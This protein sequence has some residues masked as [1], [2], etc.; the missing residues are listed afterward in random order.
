MAVPPTHIEQTHLF[1]GCN[2]LL[3]QYKSIGSELLK[4]EGHVAS[5][6]YTSRVAQQEFRE[7]I[8]FVPLE[9]LES[10]LEDLLD[11]E[12]PEEK[13]FIRRE[14]FN[15]PPVYVAFAGLLLAMG[16][17]IYAASAGASFFFSFAL[18]ASLSFPF[19]YMWQSTRSSVGRRMRFAQVL[20]QEVSRRRGRDKDELTPV[21]LSFS[22]IL[23]QNP[24]ET[25]QGGSARNLTWRGRVH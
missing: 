16:L 3:N 2:K 24:E 6:A 13:L 17:G 23:S 19:A 14:S 21:S 20:S 11:L 22:E 5:Y 10:Y 8:A 1:G 15:I 18:T 9:V 7:G 12:V 25:P 4:F